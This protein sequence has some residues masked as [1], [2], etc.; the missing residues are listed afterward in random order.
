MAKT[1][2][3]IIALLTSLCI[4]ATCSFAVSSNAGGGGVGGG[5]E[6]VVVPKAVYEKSDDGKM[7]TVECSGLDDSGYYSCFV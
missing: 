2:V 1:F 4:L 7:I 3:A 5:N 6:S